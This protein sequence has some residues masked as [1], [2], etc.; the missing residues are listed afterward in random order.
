MN[1][2]A[3]PILSLL[4]S[5][6]AALPRSAFLFG[7]ALLFALV[8]IEIEGADG[9]AINLPTWYRR[10]PAYARLFGL[11]MSG[12]PL[13][14]Y[15]A[16]MFF[17]PLCAFHMGVAF[18]QVWSLSVEARIISAYFLWN[19]TWDFLWFLLNPAY[20]WRHFR[21]GDIWW[22]SRRWIGRM[23]IDYFN[24]IVASFLIAA[25]PLILHRKL[26]LFRE[27]AAFAAGMAALTLVCA[28]V[29]PLYMRWYHYMRRPGADE[30]STDVSRP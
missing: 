12:K 10:R 1:N 8:E 30:R 18:G 22:H 26:W 7:F 4:S 15:H 29:A 27:H 14:G 13:T 6:L 16:I 23:P 3:S 17:I 2:L 28:L 21:K 20:G 9:W 19:V 5:F 11:F 25:L 24:A